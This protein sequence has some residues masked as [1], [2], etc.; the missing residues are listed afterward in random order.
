MHDEAIQMVG[1]IPLDPDMR[2]IVLEIADDF[3]GDLVSQHFRMPLEELTSRSS[4]R[5]GAI[6]R[7]MPSIVA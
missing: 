4:K 2:A 5:R 3:Y 6:C 7:W 1:E